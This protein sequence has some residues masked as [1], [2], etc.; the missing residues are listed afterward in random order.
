MNSKDAAGRSALHHAA[1]FGR[2]QIMEEILDRTPEE[3]KKERLSSTGDNGWTPLH[4]AA[5]LLLMNI[6]QNLTHVI[7][8]SKEDKYRSQLLYCNSIDLFSLVAG[9]LN[10]C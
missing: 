10:I 2:R 3:R 5:R 9:V 4:Y 1:R 8:S 7:P 6:L